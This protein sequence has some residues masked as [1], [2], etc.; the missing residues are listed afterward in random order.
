MDLMQSED[1][2]YLMQSHEN[3]E[4]ALNSYI[5]LFGSLIYPKDLE[6]SPSKAAKGK[7]HHNQSDINPV[8]GLVQRVLHSF[9]NN[10]LHGLLSTSKAFRGLISLCVAKRADI[11]G[12][13][14]TKFS[15][16]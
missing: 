3:L 12:L 2:A 11:L 15:A 16:K 14:V 9:T 8:S 4:E 7:D 5:T 10:S 1:R 6:R 13:Q